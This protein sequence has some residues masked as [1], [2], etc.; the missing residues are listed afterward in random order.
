[1][2]KLLTEIYKE[3]LLQA[4]E[5]GIRKHGNSVKAMLKAIDVYEQNFMEF[6]QYLLDDTWVLSDIHFGHKNVLKYS[7]RPFGTIEEMNDAV[8]QNIKDVIAPESHL[9]VMGD[10]AM[11][12]GIELSNDFFGSLD[13]TTWLVMGNHDLTGTGHLRIEG[14]DQI[15]PMM[16]MNG[17]PQLLMTHYPI[18]CVTVPNTINVHGH[19][20]QNNAHTSRHINVSVDQIDFAPVRLRDIYELAKQEFSRPKVE[21]IQEKTKDRLARWK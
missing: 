17:D 14:F 12:P 6:P 1:M 19:E 2:P 9:L 20:H 10:C 21:E 15:A 3:D 13:C 16:I 4:S 8:M 18:C 11:M 7:G 5:R